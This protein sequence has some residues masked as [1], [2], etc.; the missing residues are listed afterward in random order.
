MKSYHP[1]NN[2]SLKNSDHLSRVFVYGTLR[3]GG[4]NSALLQDA[5]FEAHT[6]LTGFKLYTLGRFPCILPD[7]ERNAILKTES[8]LVT[9]DILARLDQLESYYG[10]GHPKNLYNRI[11]VTSNCGKTGFVYVFSAAQWPIYRKNSALITNGDW[12][13]RG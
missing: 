12:M 5:H 4:S 9:D 3:K 8:Y 13:D 11:T 2:S 10:D 1:F 6:E 7:P